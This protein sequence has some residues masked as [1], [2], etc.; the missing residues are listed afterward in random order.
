M[1]DSNPKHLQE[2]GK[3]GVFVTL[4]NEV[5]LPDCKQDDV[6]AVI[7]CGDVKL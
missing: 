5:I 2:E 6:L 4:V 3:D 7:Q 1:N